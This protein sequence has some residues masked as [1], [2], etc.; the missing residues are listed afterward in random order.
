MSARLN[1]LKK[2]YQ[3]KI[4]QFSCSDPDMSDHQEDI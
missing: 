2:T 1:F 3:E 4:W